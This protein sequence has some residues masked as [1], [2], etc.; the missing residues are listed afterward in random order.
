MQPTS[1]ALVVA[2]SGDTVVAL[3]PRTGRSRWWVRHRLNPVIGAV[4]VGGVVWIADRQRH[5]VGLD[6][7]TGSASY[8]VDV[9]EAVTSVHCVG[10][11]LAIRTTSAALVLLGPTGTPLWKVHLPGTF[12]AP[13]LIDG[14][15]AVVVADGSMRLLSER[16][17]V[18]LH[19]VVMDLDPM[20][21]P[22]SLEVHD[23]NVVV[24]AVNGAVVGLRRT[25]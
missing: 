13:A 24:T 22:Q 12:S 5:V 17:G 15:V 10:S 9:G 16:T 6:P 8:V 18:E 19:H 7:S 3:D 2:T 21:E 4:E 23:P 25:S 1:Q 14:A 11:R 20:D